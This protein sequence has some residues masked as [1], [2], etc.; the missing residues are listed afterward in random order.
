MLVRT[1]GKNALLEIG[2]LYPEETPSAVQLA[3]VLTITQRMIDAWAADRLTLSQQLRTTF[4][5]VSGTS[6]VTV[7]PA[8]DVPIARPMWINA[9]NYLIPTSSPAVEVP[10]GLMDEDTYAGI[11]IKGLQSAYPLQAFYQTDIATVFGNLFFWPQVTQNVDIA[12]YTPQA[13]GVPTSLNTDLIGPPGYLDAFH[14]D[15]SLRLC[16]PFGVAPPP[17]LTGLV[18]KA[19]QAMT[20]PNVSPGLLALDPA[21]APVG[22]AGYNVLT[23]QVQSSR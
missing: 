21:V 6:T 14:Y 20:R 9:I 22:G 7:G 1:L 13:V 8:G 4:T 18:A 10:I 12:L 16:T 3:Q 2:I 17:L 5:L 15:L 11:A 23:D 19:Y